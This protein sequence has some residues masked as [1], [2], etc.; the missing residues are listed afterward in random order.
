M[1]VPLVEHMSNRTFVKWGLGHMMLRRVKMGQSIV[2][3][4]AHA[5]AE[6]LSCPRGSK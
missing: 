5:Y 1:G 2:E 3:A 6:S 4:L